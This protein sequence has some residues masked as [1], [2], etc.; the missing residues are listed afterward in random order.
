MTCVVQLRDTG[1]LAR[2]VEMEHHGWEG[3]RQGGM[4]GWSLHQVRGKS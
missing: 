2:R 4:D 3:G 1:Y